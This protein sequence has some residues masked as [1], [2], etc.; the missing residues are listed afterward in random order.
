MALLHCISGFFV[1]VWVR[2]SLVREYGGDLDQKVAE[3]FR[4][5]F[6][7][8]LYRGDQIPVFVT[9]NLFFLEEIS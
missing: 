5:F 8:H 2:G 1:R 9:V 3:Q 4:C 7:R 6:D